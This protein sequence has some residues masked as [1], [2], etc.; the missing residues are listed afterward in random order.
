MGYVKIGYEK[1]KD[2]LETYF[3]DKIQA[4]KTKD[5]IDN[6]KPCIVDVEC[7]EDGFYYDTNGNQFIVI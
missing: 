5:E 7:N 1:A 4:L 6:P 3:N 2:S